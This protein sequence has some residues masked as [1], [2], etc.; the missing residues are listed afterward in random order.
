MWIATQCALGDHQT[1]NHWSI[2]LSALSSLPISETNRREVKRFAKFATVGVAG[3]VT[4]LTIANVLNFG[5]HFPDATANA[6]GFMTAVLQNYLLNYNWTFADRRYTTTKA[7]WVQVSQFFV[8][9]II[10]LGIN[11]IVREVVSHLLY[12]FWQTI[13][14]NPM[15]AEVVNYNFSIAVAIGVVLFWNFIVNRLWTFRN[16]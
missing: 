15:M 16:K 3:M 11:T 9:S 2:V 7:R 5:F 12:P 14:H 8:V 6:V 4:H 13:F 1:N 10:G